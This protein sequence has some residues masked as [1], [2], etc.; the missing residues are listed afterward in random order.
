MDA[1]IF[2]LAFKESVFT[3]SVDKIAIWVHKKQ[4]MHPFYNTILS[5]CK[6]IHYPPL[7]LHAHFELEKEPFEVQDLV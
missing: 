4:C 5:L 1:L 6:P 2:W 3:P 7:H